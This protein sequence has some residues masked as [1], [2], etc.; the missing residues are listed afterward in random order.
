MFEIDLKQI[1]TR[2]EMYLCIS[3]LIHSFSCN[4]PFKFLESQNLKTTEN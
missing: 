2:C 3:V 4:Q 1:T